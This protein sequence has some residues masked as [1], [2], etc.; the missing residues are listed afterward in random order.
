M[1]RDGRIPRG[2]HGSQMLFEEDAVAGYFDAI[3]GEALSGDEADAAAK[4]FAVSSNDRYR[5]SQVQYVDSVTGQPLDNAFVDQART[6][7]LKYF[8]DQRVWEKRPYAEA[9]AKMGK[10]AI[11]VKWIDTNKGD[12][13]NPNYRSR[14]VARE[15]R[16]RG[17]NPVFAPTPPLESLRAILSLAATDMDGQP[18]HSRDPTSELR[19]QVSFI[20]ISRAYFCASTDPSDPTYVELPREDPAHGVKVGL[21]LNHMYGTRKAADGWHCEYAGKLRD[22][23]FEV[24]QAPRAYSSTALTV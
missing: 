22:L 9:M 21:L 18:N 12:E 24:G 3:A 1:I 4:V 19:T 16:R 11:T 2:S 20:D 8:E 15:I 5:P 6:L 13:D 14:L 10:K 7:E 17:E 23:G